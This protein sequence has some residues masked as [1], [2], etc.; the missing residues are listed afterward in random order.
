MESAE[1]R[2]LG[3]DSEVREVLDVLATPEVFDKLFL[4]SVD[5]VI[6]QRLGRH[7]VRI[8]CNA[9]IGVSGGRSLSLELK[10]VHSRANAM[11]SMAKAAKAADHTIAYVW[12]GVALAAAFVGGLIALR[13]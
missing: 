12:G 5:A 13:P 2:A 8:G 10:D 6:L 9:P 7:L 11:L 1:L 4:D 3:V